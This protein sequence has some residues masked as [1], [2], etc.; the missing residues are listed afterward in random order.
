MIFITADK[1]QAVTCGKEHI[2]HNRLKGRIKGFVSEN[3]ASGSC[4]RVA[5]RRKPLALRL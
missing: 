1:A 3:P 5:S 2:T 4:W